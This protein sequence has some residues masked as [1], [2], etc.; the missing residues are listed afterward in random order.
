MPLKLGGVHHLAEMQRLLIEQRCSATDSTPSLLGM[1]GFHGSRILALQK[2]AAKNS[3][4]REH[5]VTISARC[6]QAVKNSAPLKQAA[7]DSALC[8]QAMKDSALCKPA[9]KDSALC[10][11]AGKN[12]A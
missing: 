3:A 4:P 11:E 8:K 1:E 9:V 10:K 6:K 7:K 12:L 2:R 5:A